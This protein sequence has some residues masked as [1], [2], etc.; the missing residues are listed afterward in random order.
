MF[1]TCITKENMILYFVMLGYAIQREA[2]FTNVS[3][4]GAAGEQWPMPLPAHGIDVWSFPFNEMADDACTIME[5]YLATLGLVDFDVGRTFQVPAQLVVN[6]KT[7]N[8]D[9]LRTRMGWVVPDHLPAGT[10]CVILNPVMF[11]EMSL[12]FFVQAD[13]GKC[14][15]CMFASHKFKYPHNIWASH[16]GDFFYGFELQ[17]DGRHGKTVSAKKICG[18][19]DPITKIWRT[20]D[21]MTVPVGFK[22]WTPEEFCWQLDGFSLVSGVGMRMPGVAGG[23]IFPLYMLLLRP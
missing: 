9:V 1:F 14:D 22:G 13:L 3:F 20:S 7:R 4:T 21:F 11:G 16:A 17:E 15:E 10:Q 12:E 2:K 5:K 19:Q 23:H 6:K 8:E 18:E